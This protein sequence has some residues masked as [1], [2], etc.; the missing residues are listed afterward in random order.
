M[1][2]HWMKRQGKEAISV[3]KPRGVYVFLCISER[4]TRGGAEGVVYL[5]NILCNTSGKVIHFSLDGLCTST[6]A[7]AFS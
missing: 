3:Y 4:G 1:S 5:G 7:A 2:M 6:R